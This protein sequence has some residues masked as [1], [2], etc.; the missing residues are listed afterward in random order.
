VNKTVTFLVALVAGVAIFCLG[1]WLGGHPDDL[2]GKLRDTFVDDN[3]A[4]PAEVIHDIE[5]KYYKKVSAEKLRQQSA[6][7]IVKALNDRFSNYF[8]PQETKLFLQATSGRFEGVGM[9]VGKN[10]RG[11]L[12]VTVFPNS[13]AN[14]AGIRKGEIVTKV[15]GASIAGEDTRVATGKIKGPA[16]ST[17]RL[18]VLDPK[19]KKERTFTLKRARIQVP[20]VQ[21]KLVERKG[22]KVGVVHLADF[23]SGAHGQLRDEVDK[24]TKQGAKGIILDLR[25]NGGG[26]L[27]EAVLVSSVFIDKGPVVSTRGRKED[28]HKYNAVGGAISPKIPLVVLVDR[29]SASASEIVTGALK[30]RK[31]AVVVGT[32]T[33]GKGVFQEVENLQNG[34]SLDITVG[35]YYLPNGEPVSTKGI[36]PQVPAADKPDTRR[37]EALPVAEAALVKRLRSR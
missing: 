26:L 35:R 14:A 22:V 30:D 16:G 33:F 31:R 19:T 27:Q 15:N 7:G 10:R 32:R 5:A 9:S 28:E 6:K 3:Q 4:L 8:T 34:G 23:S 24:L 37:D 25:G 18:T 2:P 36:A 29:G 13:P 1:L 20:V 21:G 17:V 11:L 12:V